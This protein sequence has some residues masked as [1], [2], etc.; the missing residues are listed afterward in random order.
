MTNDSETSDQQEQQCKSF[1]DWLFSQRSGH[2]LN[3]LSRALA[4]VS[5]AV[6]DTGLKGS[7]KLTINVKP[8]GAIGGGGNQLVVSDAIDTTV[9]KRPNEP[10]LW[11]FDEEEPGLQRDDPRQMALALVEVQRAT[12]PDKLR[13][14]DA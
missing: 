13:E 1:A 3:D 7:I 4:E 12:R 6:V 2:C 10:S 5:Q 14:I 8:L 11:F 9:P